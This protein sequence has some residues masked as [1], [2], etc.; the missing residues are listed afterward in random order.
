L[1]RFWL[2]WTENKFQ[3]LTFECHVDNKEWFTSQFFEVTEKWCPITDQLFKSTLLHVWCVLNGLSNANF[4]Y[5]FKWT[6]DSIGWFKMIVDKC[7]NYVRGFVW[8]LCGWDRV[9]LFLTFHSRA[10]LK[11]VI[12]VYNGK[13]KYEM[14]YSCQPY[15]THTV[16]T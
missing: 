13:E 8:Q 16:A 9:D 10:F 2:T 1:R 4:E 11:I 5:K 14:S 3:N 15:P 6:Q 12:S 7:A